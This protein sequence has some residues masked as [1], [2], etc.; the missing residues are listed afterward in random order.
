[1]ACMPLTW[2]SI[3]SCVLTPRGMLKNSKTSRVC[4]GRNILLL[5]LLLLLLQILL[6]L[7]LLLLMLLL[8]LLYHQTKIV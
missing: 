3:S 4:K 8:L 6:L 2:A 5:L 1:M 7:L